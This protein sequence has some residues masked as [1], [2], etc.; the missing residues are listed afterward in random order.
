MWWKKAEVDA[1]ATTWENARVAHLLSV[2]RMVAVE[3][4]DGQKAEVGKAAMTN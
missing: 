3:V 1:M 4:G 2:H